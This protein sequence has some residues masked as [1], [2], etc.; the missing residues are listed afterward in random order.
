MINLKRTS[1]EN[2]G[3]KDLIR[4]LTGNEE[5]KSSELKKQ[6]AE[7]NMAEYFESVVVAFEDNEAVGCG[8]FKP[9]EEECAEMKRVYVKPG[10]YEKSVEVHIIHELENW[11]A[12]KGFATTILKVAENESELIKL[13]EQLGYKVTP[14]FTPCAKKEN[15]VCLC[16]SIV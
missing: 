14:N 12:E 15:C 16:K 9:Y 4:E 7:L 8:S 13:Y 6:Y 3:F 11:A 2:S 10:K 1:T 5:D